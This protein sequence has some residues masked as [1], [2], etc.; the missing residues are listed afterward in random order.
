MN[1]NKIA[2]TQFPIIN[3]IKNRWSPRSYSDKMIADDD[4]M[5]LFEAASWAPSGNNYQPWQF[6]YAARGSEA[7]KK[8]YQCLLPGNQ[9]WADKASYFVVSIAL[10]KNVE[11][12]KDNI[13]ATHDLGMANALLLLQG[14]AMGIYGRQM[15]GIDRDKLIQTFGFSEA[16][17][18]VCIIAL[19]YA[20]SPEKLDEPNKSKEL[21]ERERK[22]LAQFVIKL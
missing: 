10:V 7:F 3:L 6:Y 4:L 11:T 5:T 19:G 12:G 9:S 13:Y 18:P 20:D 14:T 22:E 15:A 16:Q 8:I 17:F 2:K 1:P 21:A